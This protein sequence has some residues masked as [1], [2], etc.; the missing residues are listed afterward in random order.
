MS[1][2]EIDREIKQQL[3]AQDINLTVEIPIHCHQ[4]VGEAFSSVQKLA[5]PGD[6]ILVY[7]SFYTVAEVGAEQV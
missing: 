4:S 1:V 3:P 7:G 5:N 6:I 2:D